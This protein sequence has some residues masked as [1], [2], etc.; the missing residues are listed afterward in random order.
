M[1]LSA[2]PG[3]A[4]WPATSAHAAWELVEILEDVEGPDSAIEEAGGQRLR[5]SV[6]GIRLKLLSLLGK[7]G[8]DERASEMIEHV[9]SDHSLP[10]D[11][12]LGL[13]SWYVARKGS[14]GKFAEAAGFAANSLEIGEDPDLAWNLVKALHNNGKMVAA[15]A[16]LA[17]HR[18]EP[19]SDDEMRRWTQLHLAVPLPPDD[20]PTMVGIA[21]RQPDGQFR[22]AIIG[23]LVREVLL[24]PP[25]PGAQFSADAVDAVSQLQNKPKTV[26][27]TRYG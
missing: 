17:R 11:V 23:L 10:A 2:S 8:H 25:E 9:I 27:A 19:V 14:Q 13:A 20:A 15:R 12:R 1:V 22:D 7:Y 5:W 4:S 16:A 24:T 3:C 26:P 21:Q 18:P 6:P